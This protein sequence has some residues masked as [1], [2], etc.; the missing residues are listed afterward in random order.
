[1]KTHDL[2]AIE[3]ARMIAQRAAAPAAERSGAVAVTADGRRFPGITVRMRSAAGLSV[4]AERVAI[5]A[6][7]AATDAPIEELALWVP[8]CACR[9][10]WSWH[11]RLASF[12]SVALA[13]CDP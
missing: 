4:C 7:R 1:M 12:C 6:A 11:L 2:A 10:G 8:A 13:R 3:E 5:Y 9:S